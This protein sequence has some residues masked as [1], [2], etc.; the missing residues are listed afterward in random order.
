MSQPPQQPPN[1]P[2][3][4]GFGARRTRP[5]AGSVRRRRRRPTASPSSR[6]RP[7]DP[8]AGGYGTRRLRPPAVTAP[9]ASARSAAAEPAYGYPQAP[10][11]DSPGAAR[12]RIPAGTTARTARHAPQQGY[13]YPTAPM[14]PQHM[15]PQPGGNGGNKFNTQMKIIVAAV[16]AV[17]LI[18]GGGVIYATTGDDGGKGPAEASSA[19]STGG[20]DD[21]GKGG[22]KGSGLAGGKEKAPAGTKS[23]VGFQIPQPEVTDIVHVAGSWVT[24]KAFVKPG[25]NE[26]GGY[27]IDKGTKLWSVPLTGQICA[28]SRH[29]SKDYKTAVVF[30]DAK[31]SKADKYPSCNRVG[32]ID[33]NTGKMLWTKSITASTNGDKPL[34]FTEVT[35]SGTTVAV[36]G[37]SGGAAF[38]LDTGAE[39]WKPKVEADGCE[40]LGYGGGDAL[41]AVRK[42]G[43]YDARKLSIQ[44]LNP[45]TGAPISSYA[46][47]AG[48]DFAS[49]VST[50][51]L[52]VAANVGDT[53]DD[54]SGIS[55]YF[56]IDAATGK[57]IVRISADADKYG[58]DCDS[59]E[60]EQ[61]TDLAVGNN[62]L[63]VPTE[64]HEGT[65]ESGDTNEVL[66]FDLTTGK[67]VGAKADAGERYTLV[68][69]RMD[70]TNI[71]A[72]KVPLRQGRP[73]RL[74]QRFHPRAD[75]ADGEP[76][77]RGGA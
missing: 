61:C 76:E 58:G 51:P 27:D 74:H 48:V 57:L 59:T 62:R 30:E 6:R 49:V 8:P 15:A 12:V 72:Y 35:I 21:E 25:V 34:T 65:S 66:A 70:G 13:G 43:S 4:G 56:S 11:R 68:P 26:I 50:K 29:M 60:V 24:D 40:D 5:P 18:V 46:M 7:A 36:G 28:S 71:I 75:L 37:M 45:D 55:D 54:A 14:Q 22:A 20:K 19:G 52:V 39:L 2:P 53:A 33:M 63:Y 38:K 42:C 69:L 31:P 1:N 41:V 9:A 23:K 73:D 64:A 47:P 3:Q 44:P 16:V 77:R 67:L 17:A 10:R 32:V